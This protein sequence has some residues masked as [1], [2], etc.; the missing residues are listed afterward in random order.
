M[1]DVLRHRG[2]DDAGSYTSAVQDARRGDGPVP[3]VALGHRRLSIIDVAGGHQPLANEDGSVWIVFN[4]EIY[5]HRELR[6]RLEGCGPPV[7]HAQRHRGDR[8]SLRGRRARLRSSISTACSPWPIWDARAPATGAGPRPPGPEAAVLPRTSPA[9][10]VRQRAEEPAG[11]ARTCR[12]EIDPQALDEYLTYQ[13]VPHP[14]TI[15]E[16]FAKLPPA[17]LRR[18]SRTAASRSSATG[19]PTS[20]AKRIGPLADYAERAARAVDLGGAS[21]GWKRRAAG[22]VSLRRR[23]LVAHRGR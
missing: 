9:A 1:T 3:G 5:N 8:P 13:Y 17:P 6:Q 12:G 2:P 18:L 22:G 19:S 20:T 7:P 10:A 21:C 23:R 16:G 15:F 11:S 14:Q 4:G